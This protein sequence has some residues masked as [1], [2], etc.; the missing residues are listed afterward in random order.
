MADN[1]NNPAPMQFQM[2]QGQQPQQGNQWGSN[3]APQLN[4]MLAPAQQSAQSSQSPYA[5]M[6]AH[7]WLQDNHPKLAGVLDNA[8]LTMGM[9][10]QAT[11]PEG[12]G[13]GITRA[14]QGLMGA[15]QF[16]RQRMMQQYMLPFQMMQPQV[17]LQDKLSQIH[18]REAQ[19][20][21]EHA[22]TEKAL[23]TSDKYYASIDQANERNRISEQKLT[24]S[25]LLDRAA[26]GGINKGAG[27]KDRSNPTPDEMNAYIGNLGDMQS[28]MRKAQGGGTEEERI[29]DMK[30]NPDPAIH[31][32]GVRRWNDHL[33]FVGATSGARA[34]AGAAAVQPYANT[35]DF[36]DKVEGDKYKGIG[37]LPREEEYYTAQDKEGNREF[38]PELKKSLQAG[39]QTLTKEYNA[40]KT[41]ID[42]HIAAWR[43][44]DAPSKYMDP[45]EWNPNATNHTSAGSSSSPI[46]STPAKQLTFN[47]NT[48]KLE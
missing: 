41:A 3:F 15:Q 1:Y 32:E 36:I 46:K 37:A 13:G 19:V 4:E 33:A 6:K 2:P 43:R 47:I 17:D 39:Y 24:P 31:A 48:G 21:Y 14:M 44:S 23:A 28:R 26:W 34:G 35:K 38:D 45:S 8:F 22:M 25:E 40:K 27:P 10:P 18:Q 11:G 16:N 42:Q 5:T 29:Q 9:T 7:G 12:A 30:G 20:P